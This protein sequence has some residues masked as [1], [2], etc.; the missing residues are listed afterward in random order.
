MEKEAVT[1]THQWKVF[2][3]HSREN[4][5]EAEF[6]E[7]QKLLRKKYLTISNVTITTRESIRHWGI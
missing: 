1:I 6:L 2:S 5:W 3:I 7:M 4:V